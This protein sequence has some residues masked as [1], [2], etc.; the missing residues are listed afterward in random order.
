MYLYVSHR[1]TYIAHTF[2]FWSVGPS[3][4]GIPDDWSIGV[5]K[6]GSGGGIQTRWL[7]VRLWITACQWYFQQSIIWRLACIDL[8]S[9]LTL[10]I[11]VSLFME[12]RRQIWRKFRCSKTALCKLWHEGIRTTQLS[13]YVLNWM[14]IVLVY[15]WWNQ[16]AKSPISVFTICD[17][18]YWMI[19]WFYMW[20]KEN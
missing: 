11:A 2:L 8:W 15:W 14:L 13:F 18:R 9:S 7:N 3:S 20:M 5:A 19:C 16:P 10:P 1:Y 17:L 4:G 12:F 6:S